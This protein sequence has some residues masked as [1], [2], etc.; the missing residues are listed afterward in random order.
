MTGSREETSGRRII[1]TT[2]N[3]KTSTRT[4]IGIRRDATTTVGVIVVCAITK[5]PVVNVEAWSSSIENSRTA[6]SHSRIRHKV[7]P[8][9]QLDKYKTTSHSISPTSIR[10]SQYNSKGPTSREN[11][12]Y[13]AS[14]RC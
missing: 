9:H 7:N 6:R 1:V 12:S 2:Q 14:S 3:K 8:R 11:V 4:R 10:N 5:I 13:S